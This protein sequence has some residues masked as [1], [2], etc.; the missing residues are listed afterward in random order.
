MSQ[1]ILYTSAPQGLRPGAR[2]FCTVVSTYG[3][4]KTLAERLESLSGYRHPFLPPDPRTAQNPVNYS[5][6]VITV[7]G[8]K[9]HVLS[10]ISDY[11]LDY[12]NRTNKLAHHVALEVSEAVACPQGPA[13]LLAAAGFCETAWDGKTTPHHPGRTIPRSEARPRRCEYWERLTGDPGWGGVLADAAVGERK[14]AVSVIFA[15]GVDTLR[16]AVESLSLL[17]PEQRWGVTFSTYYTKLPA[18][19]DCFWRFLLDGSPEAKAVRRNPHLR[20]IDLCTPLGP[21]SDGGALEAAREGR[22]VVSRQP[23]VPTTPS[24]PD[25]QTNLAEDASVAAA[26]SAPWPEDTLLSQRIPPPLAPRFGGWRARNRGTT[27]AGID[28]SNGQASS[29]HARR[30]LLLLCSM[31]VLFVTAAAILTFTGY[32]RGWLLGKDTAATQTQT[33]VAIGERRTERGSPC[34]P[35]QQTKTPPA[36]HSFRG[37]KQTEYDTRGQKWPTSTRGVGVATAR[38][39]SEGPGGE[40]T[41][42][43]TSESASSF[44]RQYETNGSWFEK[45]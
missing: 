28:L 13:E 8:R 6:L 30:H 4:S 21:A 39:W 40:V 27:D 42:G 31:A 36:R 1:E 11:G 35:N 17:P 32:C 12:T 44:P 18:G 43:R 38:R 34:G 3:M 20:V 22:F 41:S 45:V 19:V 7:G 2:G 9:Y 26:E 5:H 33:V 14:R 23:S 10:R 24:K 29:S 25:C 37:G 16:L 15:P